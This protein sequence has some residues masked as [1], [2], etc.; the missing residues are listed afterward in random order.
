[1]RRFIFILGILL[2]TLSTQAQDLIVTQQGDSINGEVLL[3]DP[4]GVSYRFM[5]ENGNLQSRKVAISELNTV[6]SKYYRANKNRKK[7]KTRAVP[8][9]IGLPLMQ[10]LNVGVS[11]GINY[12]DSQ[13]EMFEPQD[14]D[15]SFDQA[16]QEKN[17]E[18]YSKL[19]LG[20]RLQFSADYQLSKTFGAMVQYRSMYHQNT[21]LDSV[22]R[23]E[24]FPGEM[25]TYLYTGFH[26]RVRYRSISAMLSTVISKA[27]GN[28]LRLNAG[29]GLTTQRSTYGFSEITA[30]SHGF[31]IALEYRK[32]IA[33]RLQFNVAMNASF[34]QQKLVVANSEYYDSRNNLYTDFNVIKTEDQDYFR[35]ANAYAFTLGL[36]YQIPL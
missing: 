18:H 11:Y 8:D 23:P 4:S 14:S 12:I 17:K 30:R 19:R 32:R 28:E 31:D 25:N 33:S 1:M 3:T 15:D 35:R 16:V 26:S 9:S 5:D 21:M 6:V 10:R 22:L 20:T 29:Y 24:S 7:A 36:V 27:R 13:L 34:R 2:L